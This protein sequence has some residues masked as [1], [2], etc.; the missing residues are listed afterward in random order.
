M[1]L[2]PVS[3]AIVTASVYKY[4]TL[5]WEKAT[6][7]ASIN[8]FL[9]LMEMTLVRGL[10]L[11]KEVCNTFADFEGKF[12][13]DETK[14]KKLS[15]DLKIMSTEKAQLD[16]DNRALRF[17]LD[18]VVVTEADLKA[19]YGVEL[20]AARESLKQAQDQ[21]R[22]VEA[23]QKWA[24]DRAFAAETTVATAN[25]NFETMVAEK[26]RELAKAK[27]KVEKVGGEQLVEKIGE[28]HLEWD[29][30]FLRCAPD[31]LPTSEDLAAAEVP[32]T[33]EPQ[34]GGEA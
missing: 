31:D 17:Q 15:K 6:E 28:V 29:I 1:K 24:E 34:D 9:Q 27:E 8:D 33:I 25:R 14:S 13:K 5:T 18:N 21:K 10:I 19:R 16:L 22:V 3:P 12:N 32:F 2:L 23:S 20:K 7:K 11:N 26:D 30:S 4:W